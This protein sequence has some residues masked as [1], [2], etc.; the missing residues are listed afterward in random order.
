MIRTLR[1]ERGRERMEANNAS[2]RRAEVSK[3]PRAFATANTTI[4][5]SSSPS[6]SLS[7]AEQHRDRLLSFQESSAQRT[8]IIDEV[9]DFETP[10]AGLSMWATPQER[11]LQL[12]RQQKV[13]REQ[14]WMAKPEYE[15]R[16]VVVSIDLKGRKVVKKI[17]EVERPASYDDGDD[18]KDDGLELPDSSTQ[19][20]SIP[21]GGSKLSNNPFLGKLI[22]PTYP[23]NQGKA[24]GTQGGEARAEKG[25]DDN[26]HPRLHA[27]RRVQDDLDDNEQIILDGG[28]FGRSQDVDDQLLTCG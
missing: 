26:D 3:T 22:R 2:H 7:A 23:I 27:W 8:R 25:D 21:N 20:P 28:I 4:S 14:E 19:S 9:A 15:K 24:V 10:S 16:Q 13:L 5:S 1:E 6:S 17:N 18:N 12:K 11:A